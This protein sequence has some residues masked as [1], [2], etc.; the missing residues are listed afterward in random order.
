MLLWPG[1]SSLEPPIVLADE[2]TGNLDSVN[3]QTCAGSADQPP[4][5]MPERRLSWL[6]TTNS[7]RQS[8]IERLFCATAWSLRTNIER[9]SRKTNCRGRDERS[10]QS[11][12]SRRRYH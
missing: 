11:E 1:P 6:P 4:I 2:P 12:S 9:R 3:G 7:L 8:P 10:T 5:A